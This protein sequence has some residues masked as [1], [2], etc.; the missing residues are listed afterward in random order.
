MNKLAKCEG[1]AA[2]ALEFAILT[3][4][5]T[6]EIRFARWSE[7]DVHAKLWTVPA[8][9][10]KT[11]K[12]HRV[13]LAPRALEILSMLPREDEDGFVFIG[14]HKAKPLGHGALRDLLISL[15]RGITVHGFRSTF[16]DWAAEATAYP[17]HVCEMALAHVVTNRVEG[18]YRRGDLLA[19]RAPPDGRLGAL[20]HN[21]TT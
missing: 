20:L 12:P 7:I 16:R 5:R 4:A 18:A 11:N 13:P 6:G 9:R 21:A 10:M 1:V 15:H 8:E 17:N 14:V 2:R 19:K 3:A